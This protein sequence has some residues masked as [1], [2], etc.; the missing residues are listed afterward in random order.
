MKATGNLTKC[1]YTV[2]SGD[3][4]KGKRTN[5]S[6]QGSPVHLIPKEFPYFGSIFFIDVTKKHIEYFLKVILEW[7]LDTY[8]YYKYYCSSSFNN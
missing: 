3:P 7:L 4:A 2:T 6:D 1:C 8:L 5:A